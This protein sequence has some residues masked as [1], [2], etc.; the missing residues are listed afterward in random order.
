MKTLYVTIKPIYPIVDGGCAAM[1]SF[2][3]HLF[4]I[5]DQVD[6]LTIETHK[7]PFSKENYP[8]KNQDKFSVNS[9]FINTK[10]SFIDAF[11]NLFSKSSY[12]VIRF[13]SFDFEQKLISLL[14]NSYDTIFLES[15]FLLPYLKTIQ[16]NT[17]AKIILRAPNVEFKIWQNH[18]ENTKQPLKKWYLNQ[19]T[20]KLKKFEIEHLKLVDG[21]LTITNNDAAVIREFTPTTPILNLPFS[22][23]PEPNSSLLQNEYFFIGAYNWQPNLEAVDYLLKSLFPFI[24]KQNP[25][26]KLHIAGTYMPDYIYDFQSENILIHGK[27]ESVKD[28]MKSHGILLAPISSGSGVRIKILE[29]LSFGIPVIGSRIAIQGINSKACFEAETNEEYINIINELNNS[30]IIDIQNEAIS[31]INKNYNPSILEKNL[32]EFVK[33]C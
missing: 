8:F 7:H 10:T 12:N 28:F 3:N 11:L 6:H 19:L 29:A 4:E 15:I 9:I 2:L 20:K 17:S 24:L 31:Y 18:T 21:I 5:Y 13:Y 1:S 23:I 27:V 30:N 16:K 14:Q 32:H 22:I 25:T 33:N 26:S